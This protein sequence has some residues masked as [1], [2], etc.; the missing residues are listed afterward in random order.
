MNLFFSGYENSNFLENFGKEDKK[1]ILIAHFGT[2]HE[3]TREKTLDLFNKEIE[4]MFPDFEIRECYTSRIINKKLQ[5]KN[6]FKDNPIEAIEKI[7]KDN[8]THLLVISSNIIDGI[9]Y[10][11]LL[12]NIESFKSNFKEL[13]I[14]P[15][16]LSSPEIYIEVVKI[17]NKTFGDFSK[18]KAL[19]MVGHGT[20][21]SSNSA[22]L[23]VDYICKYL[24]YNYYVGTIEGFPNLDEIISIL[25]KENI[26]EVTLTPFMFVAGEHAKNDISI[27]WKDELE[28]NNFIVN[29]NLTPL[30]E[31]KEV[32]EIFGKFGKFLLKN[33]KEDIIKKKYNYS[34]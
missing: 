19:L 13:R 5:S 24:G 29:I 23:G 27:D 2:T 1:V 21:D 26:K 11:A 7:I 17:L 32:R 20:L 30:G 25:K 22:Y 34:K 18:D 9:E 6:I 10:E 16:L 12:K 31:I 14:T 3:D 33:K 15:P 8:F 4:K 28:K